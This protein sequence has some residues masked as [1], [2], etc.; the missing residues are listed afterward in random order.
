MNLLTV[1]EVALK[2]RVTRRTIYNLVN[3]GRLPAYRLGAKDDA[4]R[5]REDDLEVYLEEAR[6][7]APAPRMKRGKWIKGEFL[8]Y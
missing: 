8:T 4:I 3:A 5:I 6:T 1:P 2:L 7:V